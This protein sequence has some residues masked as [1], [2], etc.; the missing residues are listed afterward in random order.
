[1]KTTQYHVKVFYYG[2]QSYDV[3]TYLQIFENIDNE[4]FRLSIFSISNFC[5][6]IHNICSC[7]GLRERSYPKDDSRSWN[8]EQAWYFVFLKFIGVSC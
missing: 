8:Y 2:N 7:P 6:R 5:N 4:N 3:I 1:M